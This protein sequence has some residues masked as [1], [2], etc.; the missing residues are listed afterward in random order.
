[1]IARLDDSALRCMAAKAHRRALDRY[2]MQTHAKACETLFEQSVA[3]DPRWWPL[4][5]PCTF[6]SSGAQ[7]NSGSDPHDAD[8]R[9]AQ[10]I[11]NIDGPIAIYGAGRHTM[12]IAEVLAKA[13]VVCVIDDDPKSHGTTLWGWPV[14]DIEKP[15]KQT[16]VIVSSFIHRGAMADRCRK[17][18]LRPIVL[19]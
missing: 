17:A 8:E 1:M 12:A 2:S 11:A 15:P 4:D 9:A 10:A 13:D 6:D 3:T 19:Y 14:R 5:R 7:N 18:G 16:A